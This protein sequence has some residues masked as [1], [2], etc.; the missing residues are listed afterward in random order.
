MGQVVNRRRPSAEVRTE[1]VALGL[2]GRRSPLVSGTL[3]VMAV[4]DICAAVLTLLSS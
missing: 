4:L 1:M 2:K 3:V